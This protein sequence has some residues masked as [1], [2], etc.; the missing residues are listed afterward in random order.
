MGVAEHTVLENV[1]QMTASSSLMEMFKRA[2]TQRIR[3]KSVISPGGLMAT[4]LFF[5]SGHDD[6]EPLFL[7]SSCLI[8]RRGGIK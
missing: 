4:G 8:R 1:H 5:V 2:G 7:A 3:P 6:A